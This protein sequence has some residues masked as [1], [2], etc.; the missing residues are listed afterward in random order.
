MV[1][2]RQ[3]ETTRPALAVTVTQWQQDRHTGQRLP[4]LSDVAL[5]YI[6]LIPAPACVLK[7][8]QGAGTVLQQIKQLPT[9]PASH[10]DMR[11]SPGYST[12]DSAP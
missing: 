7:H 3:P 6:I 11:L 4:L 12:L 2:Q 5:G 8:L 9:T 1:V 10:L